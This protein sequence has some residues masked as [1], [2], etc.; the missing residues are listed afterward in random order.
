MT[1]DTVQKRAMA[2][3]YVVDTRHEYKHPVGVGKCTSVMLG[4]KI[5]GSHYCGTTIS[6]TKVVDDFH[7]QDFQRRVYHW[8]TLCYQCA[9]PSVIVQLS[10]QG[11]GKIYVRDYANANVA[12]FLLIINCDGVDLTLTVHRSIYKKYPKY[13]L[14]TYYNLTKLKRE[15]GVKWYKW[16]QWP[17]EWW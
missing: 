16:Y 9:N 2:S 15:L 14:S 17:N 5:W 13:K 1:C 6:S 10:N 8:F 7:V 12:I 3:W 11:T 4:H